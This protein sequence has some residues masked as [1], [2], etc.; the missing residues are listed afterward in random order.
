MDQEFRGH[1]ERVTHLAVSQLR[2]ALHSCPRNSQPIMYI[3][4]RIEVSSA[5]RNAYCEF[6][7]I[8]QHSLGS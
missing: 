8:E 6:P 3:P 1:N 4:G 7:Q 5:R 2:G